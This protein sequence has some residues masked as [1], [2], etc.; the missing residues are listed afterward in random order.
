MVRKIILSE[1]DSEKYL[2]TLDKFDPLADILIKFFQT[3]NKWYFNVARIKKWGARQAGFKA[4]GKYSRSQIKEK[5][6][7]M[8]DWGI[9]K[10]RVKEIEGTDKTTILYKLK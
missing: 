2:A 3:Y 8:V 7:Q 4:L 6:N 1:D 9:A 10:I 5:L